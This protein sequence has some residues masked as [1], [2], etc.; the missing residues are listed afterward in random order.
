MIVE[1]EYVDYAYNYDISNNFSN[2]LSN[3]LPIAILYKMTETNSLEYDEFSISNMNT[4]S[5]SNM[6]LIR[7]INKIY[8]DEKILVCKLL[9]FSTIAIISYICISNL[10]QSIH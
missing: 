1:S 7:R 4:N 6:I 10:L 2:D 8:N 3:D 5:N 9:I